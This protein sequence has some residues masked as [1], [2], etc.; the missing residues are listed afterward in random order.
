MSDLG[1]RFDHFLSEREKHLALRQYL[2]R[3]VTITPD[4]A[5]SPEHVTIHLHR[6]G[7]W[8]ITDVD[9]GR[10]HVTAPGAASAEFLLSAINVDRS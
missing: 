7:A 5:T 10:L 6:S 2:W 9:D 4:P 8:R 3:S 1:V